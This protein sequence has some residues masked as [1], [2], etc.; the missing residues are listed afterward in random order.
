MNELMIIIILLEI[1]I[2]ALLLV[3][4]R[5]NSANQLSS[6]GSDIQQLLREQEK[7]ERTIR[8]EMNQNREQVAAQSR[9][10][11]EELS[12]SF[13]LLS[14]S[15]LKH[16]AEVSQIQHRQLESF[17]NQLSQMSQSNEQKLENMRQ[18]IEDRMAALQKDNNYKLEQMRMTVDEKLQS[19]LETRL[20][21]S[22][23]LVSERLEMV[24]KGLGEMRTLATGVGDLKKVL[25]NVKT[26]GTW[27]EV[28]LGNILEQVLTVE[29]YSTNVVTKKGSSA[30]VEYAIRLP[31]Q[32]D[33]EMIWLPID[34]KF[35]QEDY[36]RLVDASEDGDLV[37]AE[38]ATKQLVA[39]IKAEA[40]DI[41]QKY[42]DP[43]N[44][45]DFAIMFL[46]TEGL[47]AEVARQPGLTE[48]LQRSY[49][50]SITGPN[51]MAAFLTSLSMGFRTL[52]IQKHSSEVY[53]LLRAVKTE[54]GKFGQAL[55]KTQKKLQEASNT[56]EKAA[57]RSR[58][59]EKKLR[60][61]E[62]LPDT[63]VNE[64]L[65]EIEELED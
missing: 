11:R 44:T 23:K 58:Q 56:I 37:A 60:G 1:L 2:V 59:I 19:T 41:A 5:R 18:T 28:Q 14:D 36:L 34:A 7:M 31:G 55:D 6:L 47:Y 42:L 25:T 40:R 27:G 29:Q 15:Q 61:I 4:M 8:E 17:T 24:H 22:F 39:R 9:L 57:G 20:G 30:R 21:E 16:M 3:I 10:E 62:S 63:E 32:S 53:N 54:F 65:D 45:T 38:E 48:E 35:P 50:V 46:P 51:T 49:R 12:R 26:R 43:P 13:S 33:D 52:A 64:Y